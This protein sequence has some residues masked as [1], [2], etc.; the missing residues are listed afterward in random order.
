MVQQGHVVQTLRETHP[1]AQPVVT[2]EMLA[3][4]VLLQVSNGLPTMSAQ[5]GAQ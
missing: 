3:W 4:V 2:L 1:I 5:G